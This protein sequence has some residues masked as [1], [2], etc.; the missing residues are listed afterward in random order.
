M[1]VRNYT[2]TQQSRTGVLTE[3]FEDIEYSQV[4]DLGLFLKRLF[5]MHDLKQLV[6]LQ[7]V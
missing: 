6:L 2:A 1:V 7:K 4:M 5:H 3:V